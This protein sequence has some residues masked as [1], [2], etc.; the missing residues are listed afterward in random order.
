VQ[1][2]KFG[3]TRKPGTRHSSSDGL[4]NYQ[5]AFAVEIIQANILQQRKPH[6]NVKSATFCIEM[7]EK[8][9]SKIISC[10][11]LFSAMKTCFT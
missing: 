9:V 8:F 2:A 4:E 3:K 5:E 6:G 1:P 7:M 11:M 10:P